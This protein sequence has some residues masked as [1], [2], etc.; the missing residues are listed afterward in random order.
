M[1]TLVALS[2]V[3]KATYLINHAEWADRL[4]LERHKVHDGADGALSAR[5]VVRTQRRKLLIVAEANHDLDAVLERP[6]GCISYNG[7]SDTAV[8]SAMVRMLQRR[9]N[10]LYLLSYRRHILSPLF[11]RHTQS[12]RLIVAIHELPCD[13]IAGIKLAMFRD[14]GAKYGIS[15]VTHLSKSVALVKLHFTLAFDALEIL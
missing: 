5:L 6:I 1:C 13:K 4:V 9:S 7:C 10:G 15:V 2:R 8:Y 3:L 11:R 14:V 12:Q